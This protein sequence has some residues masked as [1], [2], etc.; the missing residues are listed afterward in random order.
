MLTAKELS[1]AERE[2]LAR[3]TKAVLRKS[4]HSRDELA[5]ELRRVLRDCKEETIA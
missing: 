4:L 1:E 3:E 5:A 2:H